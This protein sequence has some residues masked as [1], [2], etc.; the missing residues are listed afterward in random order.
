MYFRLD[1]GFVFFGRTPSLGF[2]SLLLDPLRV[3]DFV[4][5]LLD[6]EL[7]IEVYWKI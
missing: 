5:V 6:L 1:K 7:I 4:L 3:F 2:S